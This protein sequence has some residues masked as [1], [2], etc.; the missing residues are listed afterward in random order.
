[1]SILDEPLLSETATATILDQKPAT[2]TMWRHLGKGP[3]YLKL[4]KR[5]FYR[6]SDLRTYIDQQVIVPSARGAAMRAE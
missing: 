2:L 1:M 3:P 6:P 5:I 4:G